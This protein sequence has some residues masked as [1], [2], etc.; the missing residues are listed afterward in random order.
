MEEEDYELKDYNLLWNVTMAE[1]N[2]EKEK[3]KVWKYFEAESI[4]NTLRI[5]HVFYNKGYINGDAPTLPLVDTSGLKGKDLGAVWIGTGPAPEKP[6]SEKLG[7]E[8]VYV[9]VFNPIVKSELGSAHAISSQSKH[10]EEAVRFLNLVNTDPYLRNLLNY[11][12]EGTHYEKVDDTTVKLLPESQNWN[13]AYYTMGNLLITDLLEGEPTDKWDQF[14]E[15]NKNVIVSPAFGF[16][17][18]TD[19]LR[20]EIASVTNVYKEFETSLST[21]SVDPKVYVPKMN[22]KLKEAGIDK[23]ITG[24]QRQLDEWVANK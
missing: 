8:M 21:G 1:S 13:I 16:V 7:Q 2:T 23:I 11:G 19:S 24:I 12:I 6:Y 17:P 20:N 18:T 14:K 5:M 22:E 10:P 4:M 15:F 9:Q 3:I